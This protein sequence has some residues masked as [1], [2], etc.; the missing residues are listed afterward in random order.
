[1]RFRKCLRNF[2]SLV[3]ST[4]LSQMFFLCSRSSSDGHLKEYGSKK[5][6]EKKNA[7]IKWPLSSVPETWKSVLKR[8]RKREI[9]S[10]S[11]VVELEWR[12]QDDAVIDTK[13]FDEKNW[14]STLGKHKRAT[15]DSRSFWYINFNFNVKL[16]AYHRNF[17]VC[18][19]LESKRLERFGVQ[20]SRLGDANWKSI[21]SDGK[22]SRQAKASGETWDFQDFSTVSLYFSIS[23]CS[24]RR[25]VSSSNVYTIEI[26][27]VAELA[28]ES[29]LITILSFTFF[30]LH[31][32]SICMLCLLT[33]R[34]CINR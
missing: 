13:I 30:P 1:M 24:P 27:S 3:Q 11:S 31:A 28:L 22:A 5:R 29:N 9:E 2:F 33:I 18:F 4:S 6:Q 14:I 26:I 10:I 7:K 21:L 25:S 8:A 17:C 12:C 19:S 16:L 15:G 23:L 34:A 32:Y 20:V